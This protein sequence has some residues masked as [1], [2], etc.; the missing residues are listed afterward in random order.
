MRVT[1][2]SS[3]NDG[4]GRRDHILRE[5]ECSAEIESIRAALIAGEQSGKP[6]K[7]DFVAF[8]QRKIAQHG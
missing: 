6:E 1:S 2:D 8:T 3:H 4:E 5:Q 7:F